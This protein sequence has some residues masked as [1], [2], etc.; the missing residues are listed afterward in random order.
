M[1]T[2]KVPY[3]KL[4]HRAISH[5]QRDIN[6]SASAPVLGHRATSRLQQDVNYAV[7]APVLGHRAISRLQRC[8]TVAVSIHFVCVAVTQPLFCNIC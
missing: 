6:Y 1:V 5:Q 3:P 2:T 7:S 4:D 8:F